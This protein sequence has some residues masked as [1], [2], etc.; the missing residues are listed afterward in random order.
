MSG[1]L[2]QML[3]L[4]TMRLMSLSLIHILPNRETP[5]GEVEIVL[6]N[7]EQRTLY[8]T[9]VNEIEALLE[10]YKIDPAV[11]K[12]REENWFLNSVFP[13]SYTHLDVYKR[14]ALRMQMHCLADGSR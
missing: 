11:E 2:L 14:Q 10:S 9:D 7:G 3:L 12:V 6:A 1:E 4:L 13:V 8:V 5:T